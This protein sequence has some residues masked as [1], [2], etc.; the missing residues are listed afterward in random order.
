MSIKNLLMRG[1]GPS[2]QWFKRFLHD[3]KLPQVTKGNR[4]VPKLIG[5]E[6]PRKADFQR[7]VMQSPHPPT[8]VKY[9][10]WDV[11]A[12]FKKK[13]TKSKSVAAEDLFNN[14]ED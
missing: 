13:K 1:R 3:R 5:T 12:S 14:R 6:S 4:E 2:S 10:H 11:P 7:S 9:E 8:T